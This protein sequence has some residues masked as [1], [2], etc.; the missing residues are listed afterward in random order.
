MLE[1]ILV[2]YMMRDKKKL[3]ETWKFIHEKQTSKEN[4]V[5]STQNT[6]WGKSKVPCN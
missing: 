4:V 1:M 6:V 2:F 3:T 5:K